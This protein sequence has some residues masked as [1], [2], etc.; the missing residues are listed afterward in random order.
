MPF[1]VTT[2]PTYFVELM[3]HVFR[4]VLYNFMLFFIDDILVYSNY[5]EEHKHHLEVVLETLRRHVL[6]EKFSKC[7]F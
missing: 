6:K 5:E 2:V 1:G 3:N 7:H 4:D